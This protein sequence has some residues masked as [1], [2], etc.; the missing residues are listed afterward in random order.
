MQLPAANVGTIY[1]NLVQETE[2]GT[3]DCGGYTA[4]VI[5]NQSGQM[6]IY[7]TS[8]EGNCEIAGTKAEDVKYDIKKGTLSFNVPFEPSSGKAYYRF[9]GGITNSHLSGKLKIDYLSSP[10]YNM[11]ETIKLKKTTKKKLFPDK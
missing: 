8:H 9:T 1:S 2:Q 6:E 4:R 3:Y 7:F 5:K 11:V 10:K